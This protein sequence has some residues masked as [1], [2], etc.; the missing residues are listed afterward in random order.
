[1]AERLGIWV[2]RARRILPKLRGWRWE[3]HRTP[4]LSHRELT[5]RARIVEILRTEG[6]EPQTWTDFT[7]VSTLWGGHG[8]APLVALR[9]DMDALPVS[10]TTGSPYASRT[11]GITHA[12]GHD[13]HMAALLGAATLLREHVPHGRFRAIFQPAEEEGGVGSAGTFVE[14]GILRAPRVDGIVGAH[15]E[16]A[17]PAGFVGLR[18]GALMAASDSFR[19]RGRGGHAGYPHRGTDAIVSAAEIVSGLQ[20]LVSRSREPTDPAVVTVGTIHG[21]RRHNV[22]AGDAELTGTVRTV[23]PATRDAMERG[24]RRR[25]Q[26]IARSAGIRARV[27][28]CRGYSALINPPGP[29]ERVRE[30]LRRELGA[31][32]VLDLE[33]PVMGAEDFSR[34]LEVVPGCFFFVGAGRPVVMESLHSPSFLPPDESLLTA[35]ASLAAAAAGLAEGVP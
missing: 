25:V 35:T 23:R 13:L 11:R 29:T 3:F 31:D 2:S 9:A 17:L 12:C 34:Y 1:M 4:E 30:A 27:D 28:Y 8:K 22:L 5:T 18:S 32:R 33:A 24:L 21:G 20:T 7:G 15:A 26:G 6:F 16:P 14:R 10:E 19:L